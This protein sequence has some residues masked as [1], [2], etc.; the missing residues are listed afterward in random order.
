MCS[1][2]NRLSG[3]IVVNLRLVALWKS[4]TVGTVLPSFISFPKRL[5][6]AV[7]N[8]MTLNIPHLRGKKVFLYFNLYKLSCPTL[9]LVG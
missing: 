4:H 9:V 6:S 1:G 3:F 8:I 2:H 7:I 5:G